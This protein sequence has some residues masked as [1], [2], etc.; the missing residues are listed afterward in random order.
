[1]TLKSPS[2]FDRTIAPRAHLGGGLI[3]IAGSVAFPFSD[4]GIN[5]PDVGGFVTVEDNGTL[6]LLVNLTKG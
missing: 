2:A 4:F 5:P 6:E 1:M 3:K